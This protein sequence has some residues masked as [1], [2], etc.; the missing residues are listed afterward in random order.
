MLALTIVSEICGFEF[1][2]VTLS[3]QDTSWKYVRYVYCVDG[4]DN[5][6]QFSHISHKIWTISMWKGSCW[7]GKRMGGDFLLNAD[8]CQCQFHYNYDA[9]AKVNMIKIICMFMI[10]GAAEGEAAV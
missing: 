4:Q 9:D 1:L 7:L 10:R 5:T 8:V 2:Q 6:S 3:G